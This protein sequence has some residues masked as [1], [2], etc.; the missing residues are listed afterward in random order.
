MP[1]EITWEQLEE[2]GY[3]GKD[4]NPF[5]KIKELE[6]ELKEIKEEN[7]DLRY[8]KSRL[9]ASD[10]VGRLIRQLAQVYN[11]AIHAERSYEET[12]L[13]RDTERLLLQMAI[14]HEVYIPPKLPE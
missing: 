4:Y 11:F 12:V 6:R 7:E 2:M 3:P 13:L 9:I 1:K 5:D 14:E 10:D 8:D